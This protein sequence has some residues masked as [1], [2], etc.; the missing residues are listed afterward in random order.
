MKKSNGNRHKSRE[1]ALKAIYQHLVSGKPLVNVMQ[2]MPEQEEP[3]E[4]ELEVKLDG[5]VK[6]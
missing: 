2:E 5:I 3:A 1:L 4:M 6:K